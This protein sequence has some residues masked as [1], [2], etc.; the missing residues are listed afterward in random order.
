[1]KLTQIPHQFQSVFIDTTKGVQH[2]CV[3][4][5]YYIAYWNWFRLCPMTRSERQTFTKKNPYLLCLHCVDDYYYKTNKQT[6]K[7][8][9]YSS[10]SAFKHRAFYMRILFFLHLF[11]SFWKGKKSGSDL[12]LLG[13]KGI[14]EN[15]G[16]KIKVKRVICLGLPRIMDKQSAVRHSIR[17]NTLS[18]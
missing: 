4:L 16:N 15:R 17:F 12:C 8:I 13:F 9:R 14:D 7:W 2:P 11:F 6:Y 18:Y 5:Y 1:M 3:A 10:V